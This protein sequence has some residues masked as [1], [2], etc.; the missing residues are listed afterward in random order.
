MRYAAFN[1][2]LD[3][4]SNFG[5][6]IPAGK[7]FREVPGPTDPNFAGGGRYSDEQLYALALYIDSLKPPPNP[8]RR[9]AQ[10]ALG[11]RVFE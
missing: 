10:V 7:N 9:T 8:N 11:E 3:F 6:F 1:N 2:E 5:D 4:L